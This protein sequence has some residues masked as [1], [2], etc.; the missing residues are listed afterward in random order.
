[1]AVGTVTCFSP[2]DPVSLTEY[3]LLTALGKEHYIY[4]RETRNV[5]PHKS[6]SMSRSLTRSLLLSSEV[7]ISQLRSVC[8]L[9][10]TF[11]DHMEIAFAEPVPMRA[12]EDWTEAGGL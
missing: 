5:V 9:G 3:Q 10:W 11:K 7:K 6:L 12:T 1:M 4:R 8:P 2:D